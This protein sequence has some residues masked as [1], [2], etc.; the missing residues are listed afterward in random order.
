MPS[1]REA[2]LHFFAGVFFA[3]AALADPAGLPDA[4]AEPL[5]VGA[6]D[7]DAVADIAAVDVAVADAV[8]VEVEAGIADDVS[9]GVDAVVGIAL[10]VDDVDGVAGGLGG[11]P[12]HAAAMS[13]AAARV[14]NGMINGRELV[15][16]AA[17]F[18]RAS[19][20]ADAARCEHDAP[21]DKQFIR[22]A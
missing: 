19:L 18:M 4:A 10:S 6:A 17:F 9:A 8:D 16:R 15:R 2:S 12:P 22:R 13:E 20:S 3:G 7:A 5:V 14:T 11:S 1:G 21:F